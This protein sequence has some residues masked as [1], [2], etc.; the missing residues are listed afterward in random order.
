MQVTSKMVELMHIETLVM[1]VTKV[2]KK[3]GWFSCIFK[4]VIVTLS[5]KVKH[6]KRKEQYGSNGVK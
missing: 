4:K 6:S 2:I 1:K 5:T 3:S